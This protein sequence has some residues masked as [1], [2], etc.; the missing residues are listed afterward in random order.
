MS[1]VAQLPPVTIVIEWEN[2]SDVE[3]DWTEKAMAGLQRELEAIARLSQA[4]RLAATRAEM[5][6]IIL[7]QVAAL[8]HAAGATLD[9]SHPATGGMGIEAAV[10]QWAGLPIDTYNAIRSPDLIY[11][12]GGGI[13]AHPAGI[14]AGVR[15]IRLAWE[16]AIDGRTLEQAA[17]EHSEVKQAMEMFAK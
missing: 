1:E 4:L 6:P 9:L 3:D 15:S 5:L 14:A 7:E 11:A 12:C 13:V 16:A 8:T 10:G 2:A 17:A